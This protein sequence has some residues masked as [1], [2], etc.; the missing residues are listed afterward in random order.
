MRKMFSPILCIFLYKQ[1]AFSDGGGD[2][3]LTSDGFSGSEKRK[4]GK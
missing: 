3:N 1:K 2:I 4:K